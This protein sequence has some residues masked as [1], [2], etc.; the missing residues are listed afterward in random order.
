MKNAWRRL[1]ATYLGWARPSA[2][3]SGRIARWLENFPVESATLIETEKK[4]KPHIRVAMERAFSA[5]GI[6][7]PAKKERLRKLFK[8]CLRS[9]SEHGA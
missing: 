6:H 2:Q 7:D 5:A 1:K 4:L 9:A 3:G 8:E